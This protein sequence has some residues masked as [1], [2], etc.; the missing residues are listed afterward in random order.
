[1]ASR[2]ETAHNNPIC[3]NIPFPGMAFHESHGFG[4]LHKGHG[5]CFRGNA[6]VQGKYLVSGG[7]ELHSHGL[8]FPGRHKTVTASRAQDHGRAEKLRLVGQAI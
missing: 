3:V 7:Q 1:M 2:G 4:Q 5:K 8:V 6:V